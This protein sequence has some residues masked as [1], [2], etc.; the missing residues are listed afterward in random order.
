MDRRDQG[1]EPW[2]TRA[3]PEDEGP[4]LGDGTEAGGKAGVDACKEP[5]APALDGVTV[6]DQGQGLRLGPGGDQIGHR[7]GPGVRT[8]RVAIRDQQV[9]HPAPAQ[10]ARQ[11][12]RPVVAHQMALPAH[13]LQAFAKAAQTFLR[14]P[15]EAAHG[16]GD[17]LRGFGPRE[18][19]PQPGKDACAR[20]THGLSP[21]RGPGGAGPWV[22][23][24]GLGVYGS[25][26]PAA[27][28][29]GP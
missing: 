16:D 21:P 7:V 26:A 11:E 19:G 20:V 3:R 18:A 13:R 24:G 27:P 9:T 22:P 14:G 4:G 10:Q 2:L 17:R 1:K 29:A 5:V 6:G 28:V 25:K 8:R 23:G 15:V 12:R